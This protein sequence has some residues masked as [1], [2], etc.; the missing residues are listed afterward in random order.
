MLPRFYSCF[1][2]HEPHEHNMTG[3]PYSMPNL[4]IN[5]KGD[6]GKNYCLNYLLSCF[7]VTNFSRQYTCVRFS[8]KQWAADLDLTIVSIIQTTSVNFGCPRH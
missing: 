5:I 3:D 2:L 1:K 6:H 8:Q 4:F 7:P